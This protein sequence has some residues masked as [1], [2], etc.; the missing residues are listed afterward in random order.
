MYSEDMI[1]TGYK[2][3]GELTKVGDWYTVDVGQARIAIRIIR[4]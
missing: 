1:L 4:R 3:Y 2:V